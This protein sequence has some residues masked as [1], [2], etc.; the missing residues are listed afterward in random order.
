MGAPAAAILVADGRAPLAQHVVSNVPHSGQRLQHERA[1]RAVRAAHPGARTPARRGGGPRSRGPDRRTRR[2]RARR[3][4]RRRVPTLACSEDRDAGRDPVLLA[5]PA[6]A[7]QRRGAA[8]RAGVDAAR[9]RRC[10]VARIVRAWRARGRRP[11]SSIARG[12]PPC[13][14]TA[15]RRRSSPA[16]LAIAASMPAR[17]VCRSRATRAEHQHLG[18]EAHGQ[19][20]D[21]GRAAAAQHVD[22]LAHLGGVADRDAERLIHV[23][24]QRAHRRAPAA[25]RARSAS[26]PARGP[27][28]ARAG[29]RRCRPSRPSPAR[30]PPRRP[31]STGSTR[32]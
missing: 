25:G 21:V 32:R 7:E 24:Q 31:S 10:R 2:C 4:A 15:S 5:Q 30:R 23:G 27:A 19:R 1:R 26:A 3:R 17:A 18:A 20:A 8:E 12:S 6:R 29:T 16:P 13:S 14:R 9:R 22:R 28:R 11:G